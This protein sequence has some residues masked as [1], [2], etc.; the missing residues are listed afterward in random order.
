M[1]SSGTFHL[2]SSHYL[3]RELRRTLTNPYFSRVAKPEVANWVHSLLGLPGTLVWL[4]PNIPQ[5]ATH[6]ADDFVI[7]TALAAK[8]DYLVTADREILCLGSYQEIPI[9]SP[10]RFLAA[11]T[12]ENK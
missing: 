2:L 12:Q 5:V 8:A 11:M 1:L 7:A 4:P 9:R 6:R 10:R 3:L